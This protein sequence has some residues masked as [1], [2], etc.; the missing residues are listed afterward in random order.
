MGVH[1]A[2]KQKFRLEGGPSNAKAKACA[3]SSCSRAPHLL[4][5]TTHWENSLCGFPCP[6]QPEG[7]RKK[8]KERI[9]DSTVSCS[10]GS[11]KQ[12][13]YGEFKW[14]N[15]LISHLKLMINGMSLNL[16]QGNLRI[17]TFC[18]KL[19]YLTSKGL[20]NS[21]KDSSNLNGVD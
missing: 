7:K 9:P 18:T 1:K 17:R 15:A 13:P 20:L 4:S 11:Q 5:H 19:L 10:P 12:R 21:P 16:L 14:W 6:S 3:S 2:L 8:R